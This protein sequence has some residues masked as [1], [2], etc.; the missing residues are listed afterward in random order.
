MTAESRMYSFEGRH[1]DVARMMATSGLEYLRGIFSA[2]SFQTH[3][4]R[5]RS[6]SRPL[7]SRR[8]CRVRRSTG[9]L[10]VQRAGNGPWWLG[11][12]DLGFGNGLHSPDDAAGRGGHT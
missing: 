7:S 3:R 2:A 6:T 5:Q 4:S 12:D 11:G 9:A 8:S 1:A 10:H